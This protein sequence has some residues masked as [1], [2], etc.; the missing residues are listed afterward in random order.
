MRRIGAALFF[1]LGCAPDSGRRPPSWQTGPG[2]GDNGGNEDN[3]D[4]LDVDPIDTTEGGPPP[5]EEEDGGDEGFDCD[6]EDAQECMCPDGPGT[7]VQFCESGMWGACM[8]EAGSTG[9]AD[10]GESGSAEVGSTDDGGEETGMPEPMPT[11][12]CYPGEDDSYTTCFP[13]HYFSPEAPPAGYEYPDALA[14]DP[15]YRR[16][17]AFLDLDE[18]A[19]STAVSPNFNLGELAQAEKGRWA[20]VQPHAVESLQALRDSAGALLCNSG[21]RSPEYNAGVAGATWSRHLYGDGYD[22]DPLS[23][24]IDA[25]EIECTGSG[26]FLVEYE[27]HVHCDWRDVT[28][29]EEFFGP[30]DAVAQPAGPQLSAELRSSGPFWWA[31][32]KGFDEGEPVRRWTALA[33]DGTVLARARGPLFTAPPG[34]AIV[35]LDIGRALGLS[36]TIE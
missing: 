6:G 20:I 3:A 14:G 10:G 4:T 12:V 22:L 9:V 13:L 16:P 35:E 23:I 2:S 21:Y 11:E 26:G 32:A 31:P 17:I 29:A 34:T 27:T 5:V 15:D 25:L 24:T 1:V 8:C 7:G 30:V 19:P 33:A 18:I 28:V 36:A